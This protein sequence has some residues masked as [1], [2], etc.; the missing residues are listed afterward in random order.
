[1]ARSGKSKEDVIRYA[2]RQILEEGKL[3]VVEQVFAPD[4]VLHA[5]SR[6]GNGPAFVK[7]FSRQLRASFPD[8]KVVGVHILAQGKDTVS[9]HRRLRGTHEKALRGIPPSGKKVTWDDMLVSRFED[10]LIA[11][12]WAVS[13][14][15]AQM[16][17]KLP[18]P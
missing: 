4:Y 6:T 15:A 14:L 8:L 1:M 7:R 11:E 13:D 9:W 5:G 12:E 3:P 16:M 17:F 18:K 2:N 10:G